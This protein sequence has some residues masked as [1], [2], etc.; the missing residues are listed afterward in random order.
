MWE[1]LKMDFESSQEDLHAKLSANIAHARSHFSLD[2]QS[3]GGGVRRDVNE[4]I[5][6]SFTATLNLISEIADDLVKE[7]KELRAAIKELKDQ[8]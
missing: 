6:Q 3:D 8:V 4:N 2:R 5:H 1:Y 7:I